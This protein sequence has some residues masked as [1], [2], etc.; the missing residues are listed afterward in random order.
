MVKT[1]FFQA[2]DHKKQSEP[3]KKDHF[4]ENIKVECKT[5]Y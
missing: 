4:D 1:S 3:P 2:Q 5:A